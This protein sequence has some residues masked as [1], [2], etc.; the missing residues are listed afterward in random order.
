MFFVY[1]NTKTN[2]IYAVDPLII[3]YNGDAPPD[4]MFTLDDMKPGDKYERCFNLKNG[5][6]ESFAVEMTGFKT[7]EEKN[8]TEILD[9]Q[10]V[11]TST[12]TVI[13][14]GLLKD[15][16]AAPPF[17]LGDFTAGSDKTYCI[18]INFPPEAGNEY[19]QALVIFDI[20]WR[21]E[22]PTSDIPSECDHLANQIVDVIYGTEGN[23]NIH[24]NIQ[25]NLI[26]AYGGNDKIDSSSGND[27]VV[28]GDGND[29]VG[30]ESGNDTVLGGPGNDRIDSGSGNDR[31]YGGE[32]NDN[33][34]TGSGDDLIYGGG[35]QDNIDG[36]NANDEIYGGDHND[37]LR[38]GTGNDKVYGEGGNDTLQ[39]NS[40]DDILDG[41]PD[42]DN[43]TGN[44]GTDTCTG[45]TLNSCEL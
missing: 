2:E 32:G 27:C 10:I 34:D 29:K 25:S 38:G 40:G 15:F 6:P 31:I 12:N 43:V 21:T 24:G 44:S 23:D 17:N 19:Q 30:S 39:G 28:L 42:I 37:T 16:F 4:P 13:F 8:F 41:G 11:D 26:Y 22:L 3:T 20:I 1:R 45:E 35:G 9:I 18:K 36:G 7:Q 14:S 5:S 33:I